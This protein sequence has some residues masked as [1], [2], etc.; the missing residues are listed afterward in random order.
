MTILSSSTQSID[1]TERLLGGVASDVCLPSDEFEIT[2]FRT[3]RFENH[4][5]DSSRVDSLSESP[6]VTALFKRFQKIM[7][8]VVR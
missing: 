3:E 1:A 7:D 6:A 5:E 8:E 4:E 2:G